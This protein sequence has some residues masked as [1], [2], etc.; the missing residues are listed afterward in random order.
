MKKI[1]GNAAIA[2]PVG[3]VLAWAWNG[4]IS[5]P[6]MSAEVAAALSPLVGAALA[7]LVS[8]LPHPN[9]EGK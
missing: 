1:T 5:E 2:A 4:F 3:A 9:Q 7:Y 8:W 6:Q